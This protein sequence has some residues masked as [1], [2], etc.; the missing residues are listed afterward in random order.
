MLQELHKISK[1]VGNAPD[2]I[3]GGGGNTSVKFDENLMAIKASGFELKEVNEKTGFSIVSYKNISNYFNGINLKIDKN[4]DEDSVKF[5]LNQ[6]LQHKN[7]PKLRPSMETGFHSVLNKFVIHTHSV[8]SNIVNC[9]ENGQQTLIDIFRKTE[10]LPIWIPYRHPGFWLSHLINEQI[11][12]F[13]VEFKRFPRVFF[14][15]NHGL[16]TTTEDTNSC[17][18]LDQ[19]INQIIKKYFEINEKYPEIRIKKIEEN[20]F[21]NESDYLTEK[22]KNKK[23][24]EKYFDNV[25]FPDQ[26]VFFQGNFNFSSNFSNKINIFENK[27]IFKTNYR[28]ANTIAETLTAYF[29]ILEK[30]DVAKLKPKFIMPEAINYIHGMDGEKHR[31]NLLNR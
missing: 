30:I 18:K 26:T 8:Y 22:F 28:E 19:E 13:K 15:E 25:L 3:Q 6:N 17:I 1:A 2:L 7:L 21:Q 11:N 4:W 23:I 5:I 27:I 10:F 16:I 20:L 29:Y 31:K 24:N 12:I 14:L 9:S